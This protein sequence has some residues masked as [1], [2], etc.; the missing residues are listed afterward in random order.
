MEVMVFFLLVTLSGSTQRRNLLHM[1]LYDT[2]PH[3]DAF[4]PISNSSTV[5][6]WPY[7]LLRCRHPASPIVGMHKNWWLMEVDKG[8]N[9]LH[10]AHELPVLPRYMGDMAKT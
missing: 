1:V 2:W 7:L 6:F 10:S 8:Q 5:S 9:G 4:P 3:A